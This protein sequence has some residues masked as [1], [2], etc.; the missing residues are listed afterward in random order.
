MY[1][2]EVGGGGPVLGG[3]SGPVPRDLVVL[4]AVLF[5]TFSLQFF[6]TTAGL[7]ALLRLTPLV[8]LAGFVWQLATYPFIGHGGLSLWFVLELLILFWFGRD[9][10]FRLGRRRFWTLVAYGTGGGALVAVGVEVL[11]RWAF[12]D[13]AALAPPFVLIQGQRIL[14]V[15]V[16]AAFAVLNRHATILLMFVLPVQARWFLWLEILFG[17]LGYLGTRDLAGFLGLG[18]AVAIVWTVLQPGGPRRGLRESW[19]RTQQ[20][21]MRRRL[22]RLRRRRGFRVVPPGDHRVHRARLAGGRAQC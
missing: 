4:L 11:G 9:V 7:I 10:F 16:V 22:D 14:N 2:R 13:A 8:W 3:L 21:W 5:V 20:W 17:F 15:V 6:A 18:A 19:L 12:P 1:R